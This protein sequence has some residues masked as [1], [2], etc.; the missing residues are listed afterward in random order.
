MVVDFRNSVLTHNA[1]T[2]NGNKYQRSN[3]G[4]IAG[5]VAGLASG[6]AIAVKG[7]KVVNSAF[8]E[9]AD[10]GVF[11]QISE[12]IVEALKSF[13]DAVKELKA[14]NVE[15]ISADIVKYAKKSGKVGV[16]IIAGAVAATCLALG[17]I[18]DAITNTVKRHKADKANPIL[19]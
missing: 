14:K 17:G 15:E 18:G 12:G 9:M 3:Y 16:G 4:K 6:T 13:P 7:N 19:K 10:S 2:D 8:K 1:Y 5:G 11:T